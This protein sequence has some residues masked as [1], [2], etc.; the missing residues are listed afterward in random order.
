MFAKYFIFSVIFVVN[1]SKA[2]FLTCLFKRD[3]SVLELNDKISV[4]TT[5]PT[6]L[7]LC[8]SYEQLNRGLILANTL[9]KSLK[10]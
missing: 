1:H 7:V 8:W 9:Y 3:D 6:V 5:L 2:D 10:Y 4:N